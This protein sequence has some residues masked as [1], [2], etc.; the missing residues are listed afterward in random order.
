MMNK[1]M[2]DQLRN[3][4]SSPCWWYYTALPRAKKQA[5]VSFNRHQKRRAKY[6]E[7]SQHAKAKWNVG[8]C[9]KLRRSPDTMIHLEERIHYST[10]DKNTSSRI[11]NHPF[12]GGYAGITKRGDIINEKSD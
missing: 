9:R 2:W 3:N 8:I 4:F 7:R 5:I 10:S 1:N 6:R 12:K 11:P